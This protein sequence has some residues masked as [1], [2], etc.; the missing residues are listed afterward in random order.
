MGFPDSSPVRGFSS[1]SDWERARAS[2][3]P[4]RTSETWRKA[5]LSRP[6]STKAACMPGRTAF[7]RPR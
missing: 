6:I 7:T 2:I 3:T 5:L 4:A 1:T